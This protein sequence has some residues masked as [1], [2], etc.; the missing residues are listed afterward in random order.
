M[1]FL[2][3]NITLGRSQQVFYIEG[4]VNRSAND[5]PRRKVGL[6]TK[7]NGVEA[8]ATIMSQY[9]Q[10]YVKNVKKYLHDRGLVLLKNLLTSLLT[11][12]T[13]KVVWSPD[14]DEKEADFYQSLIGILQWIV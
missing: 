3:A 2:T 9:V 6:G 11:N 4:F 12:Y 13:P 14:M 5:L 10:E 1:C 8:S 7:L